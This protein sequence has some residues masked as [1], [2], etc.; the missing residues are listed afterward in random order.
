MVR[1]SCSGKGVTTFKRVGFK[2]ILSR[3]ELD[4]FAS[5]MGL[6]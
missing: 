1:A 2:Q 3:V 6:K 5:I 4:M